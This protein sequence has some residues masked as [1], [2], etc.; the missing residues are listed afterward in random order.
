[1]TNDD[2]DA[3]S[4]Y[5]AETLRLAR[6]VIAGIEQ[7]RDEQPARLAAARSA[8][9]EARGWSLIEEP[10]NTLIS[11]L[12]TYNA[13]GDRTGDSLTL[14]SITAKELFGARMAFDMLDAGLDTENDERIEDVKTRYFAQL[15]GDTG[16]LFLVCMAALD[17]IATLIVP[18]MVD[19][20]ETRASNYD[21]RVMLAEARTKSWNGRVSEIHKLNDESEGKV[22][23]VDGYDIASNAI[24]GNDVLGG[25]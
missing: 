10:W 25:A 7:A 22:K 21:V 4:A 9:D 24:D 8:A 23:P 19:E 5:S 13:A 12:P 11:A 1:M 3:M 14:P 18:Q 16:L 2:L 6:E 15:N 20:L 17:T